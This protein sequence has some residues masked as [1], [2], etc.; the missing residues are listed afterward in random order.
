MLFVGFSD[1]FR[2]VLFTPYCIPERVFSFEMQ[3]DV[4]F[5]VCVSELQLSK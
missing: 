3:L 5:V 4:K 1:P 2:L